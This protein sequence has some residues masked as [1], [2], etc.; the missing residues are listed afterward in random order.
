MGFRTAFLVL[1]LFL[2]PM[3]VF[4]AALLHVEGPDEVDVGEQATYEVVLFGNQGMAGGEAKFQ[5]S[6]A[7]ASIL[8]MNQESLID[9]F[10]F[11]SNLEERSQASAV[12]ASSS[13]IFSDG[14]LFTMEIEF[15]HPGQFELAFTEL[16]LTDQTGQSHSASGAS[17]KIS[18]L[19]N[20]ELPD[21]EKPD[22][23]KDEEKDDE[24]KDDEETDKDKADFDL[25]FVVD[26][27][28]LREIAS[29]EYELIVRNHLEKVIIELVFDEDEITVTKRGRELEDGETIEIDP[30]DETSIYFRVETD[31]DTFFY[32]IFLDV[33]D[34]TKPSSV[35]DHFTYEANIINSHRAT[36]KLVPRDHRGN[37][38]DLD[39]TAYY[40]FS[41]D[42]QSPRGVEVNKDIFTNSLIHHGWGKLDVTTNTASN[43]VIDITILNNRKTHNISTN[44][45]FQKLDPR[46]VTVYVDSDLIVNC[47]GHA[48]HMDSSVFIDNGR[49]FIPV[50]YIAEALGAEADWSPRNGKVTHVYLKDSVQE[51]TINIGSIIMERT[52]KINNSSNRIIMDTAAR[53][54]NGRTYLPFRWVAEAF[55]AD[56]DYYPKT[57]TIEQVS[58]KL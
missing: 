39:R 3:P 56:V 23:D 12:W 38:V 27:G 43:A 42:T 48:E 47:E 52:N 19:G 33:D 49:T 8:S 54:E 45:N 4:S 31:D 9:D 28:R 22:S 41:V 17:K 40:D 2:L 25:D 5:F 34:Q 53:I 36:I 46:R 37:R 15:S 44:L 7:K 55:G 50:R 11:I 14:T 58:F 29:Q 35:V 26:N 6:G 13:D 10:L 51:I 57:G 32:D 24:E 20:G 18:I 30:L 1:I 16:E 21:E